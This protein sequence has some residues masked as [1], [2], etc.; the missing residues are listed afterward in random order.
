[1]A[2]QHL[3]RSPSLLASFSLRW[4][5]DLKYELNETESKNQRTNHKV[6][7]ESQKIR[8]SSKATP[9]PNFTKT[10]MVDEH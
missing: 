5:I 4:L 8:A 10:S 1:M 7:D 2:R 3:N 9:M 6:S